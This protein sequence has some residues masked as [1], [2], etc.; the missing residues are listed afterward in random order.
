MPIGCIFVEC[1]LVDILIAVLSRLRFKGLPLARD[2]GLVFYM[3]DIEVI[4]HCLSFQCWRLFREIKPCKSY[5]SKLVKV[6]DRP[7]L[8]VMNYSNQYRKIIRK[9]TKTQKQINRFNLQRLSLHHAF[10]MVPCVSL[11]ITQAHNII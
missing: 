4:L 5:W 9:K 1:M 7:I 8:S 3:H 2:L 11:Q 10:Y 6:W